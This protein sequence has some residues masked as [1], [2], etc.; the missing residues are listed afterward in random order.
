MFA[1]VTGQKAELRRSNA[2]LDRKGLEL[3]L[4]NADLTASVKREEIVRRSALKLA[5]NLNL[6]HGQ[7]AIQHEHDIPTA[8]LW[9]AEALRIIED[10]SPATRFSAR[11]LLGGWSRS[12][13]VHSL[14]QEGIVFEAVFSPDARTLATAGDAHRELG[15]TTLWDV[16]TGQPHGE[17]LKHGNEVTSVLFSPNGRTLA[18]ASDDTTARLWDVQSGQP[19]GDPFPH[20][21]RLEA[22]SFSSDG[23]TLATAST[24]EYPRLWRVP[25]PVPDDPERVRIAV[26]LRTRRTLDNGRIRTL[27]Q[28]EL[29]ERKNRLDELGG[30]CLRRTWDALSEAE[31]LE[32]RT[33]TKVLE[34]QK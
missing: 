27:T 31:R 24:Y 33:P 19:R 8:T 1:V 13:P 5:A 7:S 3:T 30:D 21:D 18:T 20:F 11:S 6:N 25:V 26:E 15:G 34:K 12:L 4:K 14:Q 10:G 23:R 2:E 9:F 32:L 28:A 29:S 16:A 17:P 22:M